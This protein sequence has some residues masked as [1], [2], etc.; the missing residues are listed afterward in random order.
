VNPPPPPPHAIGCL[1]TGWPTVVKSTYTLTVGL[2]LK[3]S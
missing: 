1:I 2:N 3:S